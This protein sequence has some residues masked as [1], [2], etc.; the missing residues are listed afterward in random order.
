MDIYTDVT[1]QII[2]RL[3]A[4]NV[5]PWQKPWVSYPDQNPLSGTIYK[6]INRLILG[7]SPHS[8]NSWATYKQWSEKGYQVGKGQKGTRIVYFEAIK[9]ENDQGEEY[10]YPMLKSFVVFNA[11]QLDAD[12]KPF[13]NPVTVHLSESHRHAMADK[14]M[15]E[16]GAVILPDTRAYFD[17]VNDRIGLPL[18]ENFLT[19]DGFYATALHELTHWTGHKTR[20]NRQFGERFGDNA[21]A[22][23]ELVAEIGSAFLCAQFGF[24]SELENHAS[25]LH[26]WLKILRDDKKAIFKAAALAQQATD[27]FNL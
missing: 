12:V 22:F 13:A 24:S 3:E 20:L 19:A 26:S 5:S 23:E 16:S 7:L 21:Y 14:F 8:T 10:S 17:F 27:F 6:G 9:R 18:F 2:E 25:Y 15:R 1:N 11:D 4:G